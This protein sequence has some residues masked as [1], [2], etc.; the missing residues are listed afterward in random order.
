MIREK[1]CG[2]LVFK[3]NKILM[4]KHNVGHWSF[5]KGHVEKGETEFETAIRETKEETNIDVEIICDKRF[6]IEYSPKRGV[7]K[8]VVFFIAKPL[9]D[10][11]KRQP[12]E[13][14]DLGYFTYDEAF[15][16]LDHND[17]KKLLQ[18]ALNLF[19]TN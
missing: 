12:E 8:K 2:T 9:S 19:V 10:D 16:K 1:S 17:E 3:D 6:I 7:L 5:P 14:K 4:I 13:I 11:L 18:D 15:E